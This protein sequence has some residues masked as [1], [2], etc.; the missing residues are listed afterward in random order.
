ML[1]D[2]VLTMAVMMMTRSAGHGART[3]RLTVSICIVMDLAATLFNN[4]A[5]W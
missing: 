1:H 4:A 3:A 2:V 5:V